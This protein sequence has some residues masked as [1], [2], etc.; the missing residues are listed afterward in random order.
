[1]AFGMITLSDSELLL[2]KIL[3][4]GID[5]RL[6]FRAA[7]SQLLEVLDALEQGG[8]LLQAEGRY[9]PSLIAI[10]DLRTKQILRAESIYQRCTDLYP[11]L[12]RL[13]TKAPGRKITIA[14]LASEAALP[15]SLVQ[16]TLVYLNQAPI[17]TGYDGSVFA[18]TAIA[19]NEDVLRY[20]NLRAVIA[21][22]RA[23][24]EAPSPPADGTRTKDQKFRILDSPALLEMD[25]EHPAGL[26][27]RAVI[28]LDLDDFKALNTRLTEVVVDRMILPSLHRCLAQCVSGIGTAY[29]EGGD[30]FTVLLPN[31][32]EAMAAE[33]AKAI[34]NQIR[35]L[36]FELE[37]KDVRLRAS[38][39]VAHA[40]IG[41]P[42]ID[43]R[44][45]ANAA[46]R[47]SK[48]SGK[49]CITVNR[50]RGNTSAD[51]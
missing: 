19:L 4:G 49:D 7:H 30:E 28:Y 36:R 23:D 39:G 50:D 5:E 24:I 20:A 44:K 37:A 3:E 11:V 29:A 18:C 9:Y 16:K 15:V 13:H 47:I 6:R 21:K 14:E 43:L 25:L 42:E 10:D 38:F 2:A 41:E 34:G 12:R 27:G 40:T 1:M 45:L 26:L 35:A 33:V 8:T 32:T 22:L 31:A 46:K 51:G 17:W 48:A